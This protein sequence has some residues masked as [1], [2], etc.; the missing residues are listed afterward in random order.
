MVPFV[1]Q[2]LGNLELALAMARRGNL[3]GAEPL[4]GQNFDRLLAQA[5]YKDAAEAAAESPQVLTYPAYPPSPRSREPL[6]ALYALSCYPQRAHATRYAVAENLGSSVACQV[7]P[8]VSCRSE[9]Y[10]S[11]LLSHARGRRA[12]CGPRQRSR[13]SR[14]SRSSLA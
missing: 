8:C 1:S 9:V 14:Q 13:S 3:P 5:Q 2:Q 6:R 10:L 11:Q 12:R 4:V 7:E